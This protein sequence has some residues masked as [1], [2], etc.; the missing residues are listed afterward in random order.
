MAS[1]AVAEP[2]GLGRRVFLSLVLFITGVMLAVVALVAWRETRLIRTEAEKRAT[3]VAANLA[4]AADTAL[5]I[6]NYV[7]LEQ[8]AEK[9]AREPDVRYVIFLDKEGVVAAYSGRDDRQGTRL[10]DP[11]SRAAEAAPGVLVQQTVWEGEEGAE[12]VLD[13]AVPVRFAESE[14]RWGT[15]RIGLSLEPLETEVHRTWVALL[16]V[17]FVA[18]VAGLA[19][20]RVLVGRVLRPVAALAAGARRLAAGEVGLQLDIR[21]GDELEALAKTFNDMSEELAAKQAALVQNL[22]LVDALR[23]YQE[24]ILR[25]M[26]EGLLTV[27]LDGRV[28]TLNR[29]GARLLGLQPDRGKGPLALEAVLPGGSPLVRLVRRGLESGEVV[30][31]AEVEHLVDGQAVPLGVSTAPLRD[32][33]GARLGLLVLL[34][35]LTEWKALE[36]RMRRADRLAALG[37]MS[38]GLAHEIK[39]PLAAIKTFVQLIPRKFDNEAFRDKF[40]VTVPRELDRMNGIVDNLL[41]LA[42]PPR[43]TFGAVDLSAVVRRA[44]DLHSRQMEERHVVLEARLDP[45]LP[46][47][48][49]DAD[50]LMRALSNLIMNAL[51]AMP[52]G[53]RLMVATGPAT[54]PPLPS[55]ARG[56]EVRVADTG[57]GMD[58]ETVSQLFNPFFTTKAKGTGLG[59]ALTHKIVEEHGGI[60]AV[61][62]RVGSG[63]RFVVTLPVTEGT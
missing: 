2:A 14:E 30:S 37:T 7:A 52:A 31:H 9:A 53:G 21:T 17:G 18:L 4:A 23:R 57:V 11:V 45:S 47:A 5:R 19:Y 61:D 54:G 26:D 39:N 13:V 22:A 32:P 1:L 34:R 59:L 56:I 63:T 43:M 44:L 28:V 62:S 38:A 27:D 20:A 16:G 41:E 6:Y 60:I 42:R 35:D 46:P 15:V 10:E 25:S 33:Q 36:A 8:Y 55:G 24:D 51:E 3:A 50:Y 29:V 12:R 40:N 48:R 49:A 58:A